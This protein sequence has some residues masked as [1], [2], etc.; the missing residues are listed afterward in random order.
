MRKSTRIVKRI[1][2]LF[3]VV[4][5]SI[6]SF[7][8]VVSDND[9][10]AFVSKSEFEALKT[11]FANQINNY[12]S[13]IDG[14]I[15]GAIASYLAGIKLQKTDKYNLVFGGE[16]VNFLNGVLA[17][18]YHLP[19]FYYAIHDS[20]FCKS[21]DTA[22][23]AYTASARVLY[24]FTWG[25]NETNVKPLVKC[26]TDYDGTNDESSIQKIY[27]DG[28]AV[29]YREQFYVSHDMSRTFDNLNVFDQNTYAKRL[30]CQY[31]FYIRSVGYQKNI[32]TASIINI[33][34]TPQCNVNGW[35][36][37]GN[38]TAT[39]NDTKNNILAVELDTIT[40]N[41]KTYSKDYPHVINYK[42][43]SSWEVYNEKFVNTCHLSSQQTQTATTLYNTVSATALSYYG[44]YFGMWDSYRGSG[45]VTFQFS[46]GTQKLA[47]IGK[48]V[49]TYNANKIYQFPKDQNLQFY[50]EWDFGNPTLQEG[51]PAFAA[52]EDDTVRLKV[53]FPNVTVYTSESAQSTNST[54][55]EVD[56]YVATTPFTDDI[57]IDT[58]KGEYIKFKDSNG[59]EQNYFTTSSRTGTLKWVMP[60]TSKIY[61]K[62]RP[63]WKTG[64][65]YLSKDWDIEMDLEDDDYKEVLITH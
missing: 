12:Q 9:G 2:A 54:N 10:S 35:A 21:K 43:D 11:D 25:T 63:R 16:N 6:E 32:E 24:T 17:P 51:M 19:D 15:D 60:S 37:A 3:L 8:A 55:V 4:L 5:M 22:Y 7:A 13:S 50:N 57:S 46:N 59:T 58:T 26:V 45:S 56:V 47:S 39:I 18:E 38:A 44:R 27:W 28:R 40:K 61:I 29:R 1:I 33:T 65:S 20:G 64:T 52:E 30:L 34:T 31:L 36:A 41:N 62:C 42:A 23:R 49:N 53:Y 48:L 14:K